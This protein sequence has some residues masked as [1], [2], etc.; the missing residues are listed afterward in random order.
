MAFAVGALALPPGASAQSGVLRVPPVKIPLDVKGQ[1]VPLTA[2]ATLTLSSKERGLRTVDVELVG[3]LSGLQQNLTALLS[4]AL[5]KDDR[6]ANRIAVQNATLTPAEPSAVAVVQL[7]AERWVCARVLGRRIEKKL[8]GGDA[9]IRIRLTPE[10]GEDHAS[11]RLVPQVEDI[12]A[13]SSLGEALRSGAFGDTI[14][15]KIQSAI[16]SALQKG[17]NVGATLP[18][19]V[20]G[21]VTIRNA[22]FRDGG[23]G[24]LLAVLD[25][26]ARITQEQARLLTDQVEERLGEH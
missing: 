11:L 21:Y 9:Q 3:D 6:C 7:H 2:S 14:R 1:P 22:L 23:G 5:D 17:T 24:R 4:S 10:V 19:A 8:I 25:G 18:P 20:Q 26:E 15:E 16:L 12:Q 13:N